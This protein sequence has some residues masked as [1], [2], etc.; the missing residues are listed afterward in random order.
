MLHNNLTWHHKKIFMIF[1]NSEDFSSEFW[2]NSLLLLVEEESG[3]D[4]LTV[5]TLAITLIQIV[6]NIIHFL[7]LSRKRL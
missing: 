4:L 1:L 2:E 6:T 7:L 5:R 3:Y